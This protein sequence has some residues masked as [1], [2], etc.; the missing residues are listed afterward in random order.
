MLQVAIPEKEYYDEL[1]ERFVYTKEQILQMEHS[2]A[3]ISKWEAKWHIPFLG[4]E[5]KTEE[6][7]IDYFRCMTITE[8]VDPLVYISL[9]QDQVSQ[10]SAYIDDKMTATW[11]SN[12][13]NK[14]NR[15]IITSEVIYYWMVALEIPFECEKWHLNRLLTLVQVCNIKNAPAKKMGRKEQFRQNKAINAARKQKANSH[16]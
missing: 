5:Q 8:D 1:N 11:F 3:S 10:I 9:T 14:M 13:Q 12:Q 2:L 7:T 15:D 6:Q 4:K 16:G